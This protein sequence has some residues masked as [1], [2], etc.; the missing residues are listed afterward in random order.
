MG[1][2]RGGKWG[3]GGGA[4]PARF[5]PADRKRRRSRRGQSGAPASA[6]RFPLPVSPP[7]PRRRHVPHTLRIRPVSA[8][9]L[10]PPVARALPAARGLRLSH[11]PAAGPA[12]PGPVGP[13]WLPSPQAALRGGRG[14]PQPCGPCLRVSARPPVGVP[15]SPGTAAP[16]RGGL[17]PPVVIFFGF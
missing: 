16:P 3:G 1:R 17:S 10:P 7:L 2:R 9:P 12:F 14:G 8:L 11:G 13:G 6:A 5:R 4:A 15:A